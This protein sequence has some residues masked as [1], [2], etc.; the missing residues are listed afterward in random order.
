MSCSEESA[1]PQ[2]TPIAT[3][4]T[5]RLPT[6]TQGHPAKEPLDTLQ[7]GLGLSDHPPAPGPLEGE[8]RFLRMSQ[9]QRQVFRPRGGPARHRA[10]GPGACSAHP[11]IT[12]GSR[13]TE[14]RTGERGAHST[15]CD[16]SGRSPRV[17]WRE[18]SREEGKGGV[19]PSELT[20]LVTELSQKRR[21]YFQTAGSGAVC[22]KFM[23]GSASVF[24]K[25]SC[26]GS[27]V[28]TR[29]CALEPKI[30]QGQHQ[31]LSSLLPGPP[32]PPPEHR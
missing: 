5:G 23:F 24:V 3:T 8:P 20:G 29:G 4:A 26:S 7:R 22:V 6:D 19:P 31:L 28:R 18:R 13:Q 25:F 10:T 2:K 30:L 11:A 15:R 14:G 17:S 32:C 12:M 1:S 21:K 16:L 9:I 27:T